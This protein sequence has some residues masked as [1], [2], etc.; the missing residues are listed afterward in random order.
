LHP[1]PQNLL[2]P[3]VLSSQGCKPLTSLQL[4]NQIK[5]QRKKN[6]DLRQVASLPSHTQNV[7]INSIFN[8]D[9]KQEKQLKGKNLEIS[10]QNKK[11]KWRVHVKKKEKNS[12]SKFSKETRK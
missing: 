1:Q 2:V 8:K 10:G 9:F 5:G 4:Q 6:V 12:V 7:N 3:S 11:L